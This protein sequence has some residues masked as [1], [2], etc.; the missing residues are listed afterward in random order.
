MREV[1]II[2]V[3]RTP[4]G[5]HWE[6][7]L[8]EI[9]AGAIQSAMQ[10]A[11][12]GPN[13]IDALVI[14][15]AL[16]GI[17]DRQ[18]H[19]GPLLA[20]YAGLRGIEALVVEGADAAGGLAVRQAT[21]MVKSGEVDTV[22]VLGAEKITDDT[23]PSRN[24]AFGAFTDADYEAA[25]GA[26]PTALAGLLM[27]RYLETYGLE[28]GQFEG[29]SMN[30]HANGARN[31]DAMFRNLIKPGRFA[32]APMVASP[33]NLFDSAPEGDGAA[34]LI[35]TTSERAADRVPRP[36]RIAG[37]GAATDSLALHERAN[38]LYLQA[39]N[40][41][42]GRALQQAGY[43]PDDMNLVELHDTYTVL[44]ALQ[45]EAAGFAAEGEGWKLA[46]EGQIGLDGRLP[47][48]TFGGL[49]ARGHALGATGVYQVAEVALQLRQQAGDNQV[50]GAQRGMTINLGGL[51][52]TAV[53]HV[54]ERTD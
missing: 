39:V 37:S 17:I 32:T 9:A 26:T 1:S 3:G 30:A 10:D 29:F 47:I 38:L 34:A 2:G 6:R 21:L 8:R 19:L 41:A 27:R 31:K 11:G 24:S 23:G 12:L 49:K 18:G 28:L 53:A 52:G 46:S 42:V 45:L 50:P 44:S 25:H 13:D 35:I 22:L 40:T 7:G 4:I 20:D 5:E 15:N 54:L 33:V 36:V 48:S 14:G 43:Q 51:G 16:S